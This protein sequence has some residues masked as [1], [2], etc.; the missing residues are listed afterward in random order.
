MVWF[1]WGCTASC[2][3]NVRCV[4]VRGDAWSVMLSPCNTLTKYSTI[5]HISTPQ[6][7]SSQH[8]HVARTQGFARMHPVK[9]RVAT[10]HLHTQSV[11]TRR[12]CGRNGKHEALRALS[13][14]R[15]IEIAA[16]Q[17]ES[18]VY[19]A[20]RGIGGGWRGWAV[21]GGGGGSWKKRCMCHTEKAT[22][23]WPCH[24]RRFCTETMARRKVP[25]HHAEY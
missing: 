14:R 2:G 12:R 19:R 18:K 10:Q 4:G 15:G 13:S 11:T 24:E 8:T 7:A 23:A 1:R 3:W 21:A 9:R 6:A 20:P 16:D 22:E 17:V 25:T 5:L